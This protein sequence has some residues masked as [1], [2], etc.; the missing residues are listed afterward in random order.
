MSFKKNSVEHPSNTFSLSIPLKFF[1]IK[2]KKASKNNRTNFVLLKNDKTINWESLTGFRNIYWNEKDI[3]GKIHVD[4]II[5]FLPLF[6][7][8]IKDNNLN[9]LSFECKKMTLD[10]L[11]LSMTGRSLGD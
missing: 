3:S 6:L 5:S 7:K 11:F 2:F 1:V 10:D 8:I 4:D 9:L